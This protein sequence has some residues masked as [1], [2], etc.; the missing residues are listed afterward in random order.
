VVAE[1]R[2]FL[3]RTGRVIERHTTPQTQISWDVLFRAM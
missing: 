1:E 3:D 2:I